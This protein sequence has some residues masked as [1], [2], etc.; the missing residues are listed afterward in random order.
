MS[1]NTVKLAVYGTPPV[2]REGIVGASPILPGMQV[3]LTTAG[4]W[5]PNA[6]DFAGTAVICVEG[7]FNGRDKNTW[8][9]P[10]TRL[11][12][13]KGRPGDVFDVLLA[14]GASCSI[15][16]Y[17]IISLL[18]P[19]YVEPGIAPDDYQI[20][21]IALYAATGVGLETRVAVEV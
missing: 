3:F 18:N 4:L 6:T 9:Q 17:M 19:G 20:L 14:P 16:D 13:I 15:G 11:T 21:G 7:Q 1:E 12:V 10:G 5:V 8:Y 2:E